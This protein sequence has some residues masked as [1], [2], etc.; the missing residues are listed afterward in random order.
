MESTAQILQFLDRSFAEIKIPCLGNVNVD[1]ISSRLLA[2]RDERQWILV[3]NSITWCPAGEGLTTIIEC[4]GN[5]SLSKNNLSKNNIHHD[6]H[7]DSN[8]YLITG[9]IEYNQD[10]DEYLVSVRDQSID[11]AELNI[12]AH[13]DLYADRELDVAIAL[14]ENYREE[15]L[16]NREE[17]GVFIPDGMT[18]ILQLEQWQ[19]PDWDR[20]PSQTES[21]PLIAEV[22]YRGD[23]DLYK[24]AA[25]PNTD[26]RLW[27]PK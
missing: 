10:L 7:F 16:A 1:Y 19:H 13:P 26:W 14:L 5:C 24:H 9:K 12:I 11:L 2:F 25:H 3:F 22:L 4:V 27:F 21:F 6:F 8:R 18:Q 17:Y 23:A 15:L 20:P